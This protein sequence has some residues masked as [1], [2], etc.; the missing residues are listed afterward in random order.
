MILL[1]NQG[2][3]AWEH[4]GLTFNADSRRQPAQCFRTRLGLQVARHDRWGLA[5]EANLYTGNY[6]STNILETPWSK[7]E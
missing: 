6:A 2:I 5:D 1:V 7:K 3:A 4:A